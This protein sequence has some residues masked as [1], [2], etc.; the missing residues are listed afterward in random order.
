M[1]VNTMQVIVST[2]TQTLIM[3]AIYILGTALLK[4]GMERPT[5]FQVAV[6]LEKLLAPCPYM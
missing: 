5:A 4:Q 3:A 2:I 1:V 6:E